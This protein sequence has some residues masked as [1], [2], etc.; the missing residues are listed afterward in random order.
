M[1]KFLLNLL[2]QISKAFVYFKIQ[3]LFGNNFSSDS[4]P[5][6][7]APAASAAG[8]HAR[9]RPTRPEQPWR[10]CQ[11]VPLLRVCVVHQWRFLS[12]VAAKWAPPV[13]STPFLAPTSIF[14]MPIK[15]PY[16]PALIPPLESSLTPPPPAINGVGRK[17]QVVTHQHFHPERPRPPIKG[18]HHP[19]VSPYL[20]PLLFPSLHAS[21]ALSPSTD[22]AEPSPPSPG[23]HVAPPPR[24]RP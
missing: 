13:R 12:H 3:I 20:S 10:I 11:K 1:S 5:S 6:G 24:V 23:L 21:A 7:L 15:A 22:A 17:S 19:R 14:E 18:E 9:A 4:G 2:V 8:R 16:S